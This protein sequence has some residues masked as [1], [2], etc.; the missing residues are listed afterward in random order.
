MATKLLRLYC[1]S[2]REEELEGDLF[3]MYQ[4]TLESSSTNR[5]NLSYWWMVIV[6]FRRYAFKTTKTPL[7]NQYQ[8]MRSILVHNI[9]MAWR[10]LVKNPSITAIN[11]IGLAIGISAFLG[12]MS[13]VQYEL[14]FN[15][16]I[17]DSDRIYRVYSQF[18]GTYQGVNRGITEKAP[19]YIKENFT[20]LAY[21]SKFRT[22]S[23]DA[24]ILKKGQTKDQT[25]DIEAIFCDAEY[26]KVINQYEWLAGDPQHA[27]EEPNSVV[28][29]DNQ[30]EIYFGK[31]NDWKE[32]LDKMVIYRDSLNTVVKG[33]VHL[34]AK[35]TDFIMSDFISYSTIEH[36][37][38]KKWF[39]EP[40]WGS[41]TSA[42]QLFIKLVPQTLLSNLE[43]QLDEF[44]LYVQGLNDQSDLDTEFKLQPLSDLHYNSELYVF[45]FSDAVAHKPALL[46]LSIVALAILLIAIFNFINLETIQSSHKNKE[47]GIR[48]ALGS[49]RMTLI[50]R[51]LTES[52]L[53]TLIATTLAIPVVHFS[54][55]YFQEFVPSGLTLPYGKLYFWLTIFGFVVAIGLIA[56]AY[57]SW[58]SSTYSTS[59]ALKSG[60]KYQKG[61]GVWLRKVLITSQ[62]IF[63]QILIV[64]TIIIIRQIDFM[65]TEDLGFENKGIIS[66]K[67]PY[68]ES[69]SKHEAFA[70]VLEQ[71]AGIR[72][73]VRGNAPVSNSYRS[74]VL[75]MAT[76]NDPI[77]IDVNIKKADENYFQFFNIDFLAGRPAIKK[78]SPEE[79]VINKTLMSQLNILNPSEALNKVLESDNQKF[80]IVGVVNDIH[81]LSLNQAI[82]PQVFIHTDSPNELIL[83]T[84][85]DDNFQLMVDQLTAK[86]ES[87]YPNDPLRMT[88]LDDTIKGFYTSEIKIKKLASLATV[89]S[90]F[91]SCL[92]LLGLISFTILQKSKEIGIRKILGA[93]LTNLSRV[94]TREFFYL[95]II[96]L[97]IST[98]AAFFISRIWLQNFA[99]QVSIGWWIYVLAG[100]S[101]I[102]IAFST[103]SFKI[104]QASIQNPVE[105]LKYE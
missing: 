16:D 27:L 63:S 29:T 88:F 86:W 93:S 26:F 22:V 56:G 3:E 76:E 79:I 52:I 36:S 81:F 21:V 104:W 105:S 33:I 96:A 94:L 89:L 67:K 90:I 99:Y 5:A 45:D 47:V 35:N 13:I 95:I 64:S 46:V 82:K 61:N 70:T 54:I 34:N 4:I 44:K 31:Q 103:I 68:Y 9:K 18:T 60:F 62:F 74:R 1:S 30:A 8:H 59:T 39:G 23:M 51:F 58:V 10:N 42:S 7:T 97:F 6:G 53:V 69:D 71:H 98:P 66:I 50:G 91:I 48:K 25:I 77:Q 101:S 55:Q 100:L 65:L 19:D 2:A 37:W 12:I 78:S 11:V 72:A 14:S 87:L 75:E 49:N 84:Q 83:K 85:L 15:R 73:M 40:D 24:T 92:G 17:P 32:V 102:V 57:P 80:H 43:N 41:V 28:L 38:V 20:G